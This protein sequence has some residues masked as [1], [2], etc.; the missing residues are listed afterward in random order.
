MEP[1]HAGQPPYPVATLEAP[2]KV[3]EG[4][5]EDTRSLED[6]DST[7]GLTAVPGRTDAGL[8]V[9][10]SISG[11]SEAILAMDDAQRSGQCNN[12]IM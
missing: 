10:S 3:D 9:L 8:P 1:L 6:G 7:M 11:V 4:Y 5:S 2:F 12:P